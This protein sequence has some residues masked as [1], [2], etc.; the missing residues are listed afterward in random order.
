MNVGWMLSLEPNIQFMNITRH[1]AIKNPPQICNRL[2][3]Q[4][5]NAATLAQFRVGTMTDVSIIISAL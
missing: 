2:F 1:V 5:E 3:S 4:S